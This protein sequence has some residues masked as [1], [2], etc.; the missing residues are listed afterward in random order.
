MKLIL[1]VLFVS[2]ISFSAVQLRAQTTADPALLGEI[3]KIKAID[4]HA[5]PLKLTAEGE[6]PD[7]EFDALPLESIELFPLPLRL[8]PDNPEFIGAWRDMYGYKNA[9]M[10]EAHLNE[11]LATKQ[12]VRRERGDGYPAW[13]LDQ[14]NIETMFANRVAMGRGLAPARF[15]WVTFVDALLFPLS[16]EAAKKSNPDYRG[17]YPGEERLLKRYLSDLKITALPATLADYLKQIVTPTL[18][19][20]KRAGAV[21]VKFE[22]AYL[23]KLDFDDADET[24]ARAIYGQFVKGGEAPAADYKNLQDFLFRYIAREA[25]RLGMAVH[26]HAIDGAGGYY[27]PSGSDPLLLESAFNDPTL[28]KTN[29][30]IVHGGAPFTK[31]TASMMGKPNVYADFSAQTFFLYPRALSENLRYWLES[32]P[33]RVLF[34]TDAFSFGPAVD[35]GEVAWLSNS[36]ARQALALALTGMMNDGEITRERALELARMVLRDNAIKLYGLGK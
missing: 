22:A 1:P 13:I 12:S 3:S 31:Q 2:V 15:R 19:S 29:F 7:D 16:N 23:R 27:R 34:G 8:R 26:L 32:Y 21:A 33:D 5:H 11:L 24:R 20:Q 25:G 9:D 28:R 10:S 6:K 4:N 30:V 35:W 36:T 18:E 17:F 14:L